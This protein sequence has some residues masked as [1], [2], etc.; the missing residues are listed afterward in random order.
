MRGNQALGKKT[1]MCTMEDSIRKSVPVSD[2]S[3]MKPWEQRTWKQVNSEW[4]ELG[5]EDLR[6]KSSQWQPSERSGPCPEDKVKF[7]QH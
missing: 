4:L 7:L 5:V 2:T 6:L 1:E 3:G